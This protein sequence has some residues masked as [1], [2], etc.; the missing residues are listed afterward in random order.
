MRERKVPL[1]F[2][3]SF[4]A[5]Y[6][7]TAGYLAFQGLFTAHVTGNFVTIG[8]A[9]VFGTSGVVAKML[10]LPVFCIVVALVRLGTSPAASRTPTA[11]HRN[12]LLMEL[13]LLIAASALAVA[14][15]PFHNGDALPTIV[16]GLTFV[17][18]MAIQNALQRIHLA[19]FPP[20]T[21][22]TGNVTQVV[23]DFVDLRR[24]VVEETKR[25]VARVR[26]FRMATNI[27][28]F[29]AGCALGAFLLTVIGMWSFAVAPAVILA[30][31]FVPLE[32][33]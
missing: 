9:L 31:A 25:T 1:P 14:L 2:L 4:V 13:A 10:A 21:L 27:G 23:I 22:M 32:G 7:D 19:T 33:E 29:A 11:R 16:T 28:A 18:A 20:T 24:K 5:G 17:A 8:A 26:L 30:G 3:L 6:V 12:M 15:G